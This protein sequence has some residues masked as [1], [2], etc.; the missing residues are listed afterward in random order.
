MGRTSHPETLSVYEFMK[1][2]PDEESARLYLEKRRWGQ[3]RVCPHCGCDRTV[4]V[5]NQKPMPYRCQ[6]CRKHFSVRTGTVLGE[7]KIELHK[8]LFAIYLM[9]TSRKGISSIQ[10]A[11]ELGVTQKT[12]WFLAHRIREAYMLHNDGGLLGPDVE[13]D[14]VYIGGKEKNKHANK[15][16]ESGR[17]AVGKQAVVGLKDRKGR[18]KAFPISGTEK[19]DLQSAIVENIKR[20]SNVYTD[21]H[22]SYT[23]IKGY[24]HFVVKHSVGE[25]VNGQAHTNGV[26]SFWALLKRGYYGTFHHMSVKHLHRYVNEFSTRHNL[27]HGTVTSLDALTS[28]FVGRRL[29]YKELTA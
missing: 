4:E 7:S 8:W 2:F 1:A 17:G 9:T 6:G 21:C 14:E 12:A 29:T 26:E 28:S 11:K 27:G 24:N 22:R 18:V 16:N 25:Y 15:R 20:G 3:D 10:L 19:I 13:V 23:G 5:K